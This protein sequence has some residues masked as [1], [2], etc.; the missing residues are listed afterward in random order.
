MGKGNES[1]PANNLQG[2]VDFYNQAVDEFV[3]TRH[4]D[5][6]QTWRYINDMD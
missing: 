5:L 4:P 1:I 6:Y 2:T 3:R